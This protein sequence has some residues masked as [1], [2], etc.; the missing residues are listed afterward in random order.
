MHEEMQGP[1]NSWLQ[2]LYIV[3]EYFVV[4][5]SEDVEL[6]QLRH[7]TSIDTKYGVVLHSYAT[8]DQLICDIALF[9]FVFYFSSIF[10]FFW[11]LISIV[12]GF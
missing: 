3:T 7:I 2:E 8:P 11:T 12:R 10:F 6:K 4:R 9:F 1:I 5:S